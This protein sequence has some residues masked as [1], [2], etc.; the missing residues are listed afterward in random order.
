[1]RLALFAVVLS[2]AAL[3]ALAGDVTVFAAASLKNALDE[4]AAGFT[5]KTGH[6]VTISYASSNTL[7]KQIIEGAPADIFISAN[8][9]WMDEVEKE[10]LVQHRAELLGN[11]L[12]L[13]AHGDAAP[14]AIGADTDLAAMLDGEKLAMALVDSVP[15]GRYG[16]AALESL[17]LWDGVRTDVAQSDNVRAVLALV[18]TGEAPLGI[19]YASDAAAEDDVTVVGE[20]PA[21]SHPPI[22]YLAALL[23]GADEADGAFYEVFSG[24]S[25]DAI[26]AR[27]GFIVMD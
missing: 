26:F 19:V 20:F 24:A 16:K 17:G 11:R 18:A 2:M 10:G 1:M 7:A 27:H 6:R 15:A 21:N 3:P 5:A 13:I 9:E 8:T 25:A 4:V 22:T 23:T 14:A 12:V